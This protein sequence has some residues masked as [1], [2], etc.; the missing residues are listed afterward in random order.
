MAIIILVQ[1]AQARF[2]SSMRPNVA[3]AALAL[4]PNVVG[5]DMYSVL[6]YRG[7]PIIYLH[8]VIS[9]SAV[10]GQGQIIGSSGSS[11]A[12]PVTK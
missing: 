6:W 7:Q 5:D 8:A 9:R 1:P 10:V 12:T 3:V 2:I 4:I 11:G